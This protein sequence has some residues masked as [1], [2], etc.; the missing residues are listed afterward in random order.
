MPSTF[1]QWQTCMF[2]YSLAWLS[3]PPGSAAMATTP[4]KDIRRSGHFRNAVRPM[5]GT[6]D[7]WCLQDSWNATATGKQ[8]T[9]LDRYPSQACAPKDN[10]SMQIENIQ[11]NLKPYMYLCCCC[12]VVVSPGGH[13][14][15]TIWNAT[16]EE[17]PEGLLGSSYM[18]S[19]TIQ[20][21]CRLQYKTKKPPSHSFLFSMQ[22]KAK[23][24]PLSSTLPSHHEPAPPQTPTPNLN[25]TMGL[26]RTHT[27]SLAPL[28]R[29]CETTYM[30]NAWCRTEGHLDL[31]D[32]VC[33]HV[34]T[35]TTYSAV[36]QQSVLETATGFSGWV[37]LS[38]GGGV[39]IK[40]LFI[41][42]TS[43]SDGQSVSNDMPM[44]KAK[45]IFTGPVPDE[46]WSSALFGEKAELAK[47]S[48]F[49]R[50]K[51]RHVFIHIKTRLG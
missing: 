41:S 20:T 18:T 9:S 33:W 46:R 10:L 35:S 13:S 5:L 2:N 29:D 51:P 31:T 1:C 23:C 42:D 21:T 30:K 27:A 16:S 3:L 38:V 12:A 39:S 15:H 24:L 8:Q 32:G 26:W 14:A 28:S 43:Q 6:R 19:H 11:R 49:M 37:R 36:V 17:C 4:G 47:V 45:R 34:E 44:E 7:T 40:M 22:T 50:T 25:F 48:M